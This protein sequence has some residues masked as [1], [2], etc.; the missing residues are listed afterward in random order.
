MVLGR[1]RFPRKQIDGAL[2]YFRVRRHPTEIDSIAQATSHKGTWGQTQASSLPMR[3]VFHVFLAGIA[4]HCT[5]RQDPSGKARLILKL[6]SKG[7]SSKNQ[8]QIVNCIA[9]SMRACWAASEPAALSEKNR[10]RWDAKR[11]YK[12]NRRRAE[13]EIPVYTAMEAWIHVRTYDGSARSHPVSFF[14]I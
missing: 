9:L 14:R 4:L 1:L 5:T 6:K 2:H 7:C 11:M 10:A 12:F 8:A 13:K 3:L